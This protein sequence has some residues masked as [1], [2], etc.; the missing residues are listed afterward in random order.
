[1]DNP[2]HSAVPA[3]AGAPA[4]PARGPFRR[5]FRAAAVY[6]LAGAIMI[7]PA[8]ALVIEVTVAGDVPEGG[9]S[10]SLQTCLLFGSSAAWASLACKARRERRG[11][12]R[13]YLFVAFAALAMF[14]REL[15]GFF[16]VVLGHGS[17]AA[18]DTAVFA[19]AVFLLGRDWRETL[20]DLADFAESPLGLMAFSAVFAAVAFS[21]LLGWK[22]VWRQVFEVG[23]W[24]EV[25]R[26]I[27]GYDQNVERHVKNVVEEAL[28][29][30]S[31]ASLLAAAAVPRLL[32]P[33]PPSGA[34]DGPGGDASAAN[35]A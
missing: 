23:V 29:L 19:A 15:D 24:D 33:R 14:V 25:K 11:P 21:Q 5:L 30:F 6:A 31:Y 26:D 17:W 10:E 27:V 8:L 3:G 1:M 2:K 7:A 28:E 12:A 20:T 34:A 4:S 16:D 13:A 22:G 32:A 35:E 9:I 18:V